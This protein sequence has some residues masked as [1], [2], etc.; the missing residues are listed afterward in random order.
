MKRESEKAGK[1]MGR[2]IK[3]LF[4]I[5]FF[6]FIGLVGYAYI[7]PFFGAN[8]SAPQ[9]EVRQPLLLNAD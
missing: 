5:T 8:F 4:F 9:V 7:G 6:G 3:L 1:F 2:L